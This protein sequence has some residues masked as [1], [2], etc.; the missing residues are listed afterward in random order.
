MNTRF[1]K[2]SSAVAIAF[3]LSLPSIQAY[4][5][6]SHVD[7]NAAA[8]EADKPFVDWSNKLTSQIKAD[9]KYKRIPLDTTAQQNE[10]VVWMHNAYRHRITKQ[11]F[12]SWVNS[13]YLNHRYETAF[14]VARLP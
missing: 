10:F 3:A 4:A 14:I 9:S 12:A 2:I 6:S 7:A 8:A 13:H 1:K 11:E 5:A